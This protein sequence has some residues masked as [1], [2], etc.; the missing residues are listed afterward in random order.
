[1]LGALGALRNELGDAHGAGISA[2]TPRPLD[3]RLVVNLAFGV[4]QYFIDCH[5]LTPQ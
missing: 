4:S 2:P 5:R 3:A 1:M